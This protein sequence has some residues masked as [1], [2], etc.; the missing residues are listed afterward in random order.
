MDCIH[1]GSTV[2]EHSR[3]WGQAVGWVAFCLR[4]TPGSRASGPIWKAV[5]FLGNHPS[6][7]MHGAGAYRS[8]GLAIGGTRPCREFQ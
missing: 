3:G 7:G 8:Y 4:A 2:S 1:R 6:D 5:N